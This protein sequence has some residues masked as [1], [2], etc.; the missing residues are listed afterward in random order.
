[1]CLCTSAPDSQPSVRRLRG[2]FI[3]FSGHG[4]THPEEN[5]LVS[6]N[7]E[8]K[9]GFVQR[10]IREALETLK[11]IPPDEIYVIP[12]RLDETQTSY[13]EL[14]ELNWV[15][16]FPSDSEGLEKICKA[17]KLSG[18]IDAAIGGAVKGR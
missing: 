10:E 13:E 9:R 2:R 17:L 5:C 1:M 14:R 8:K 3:G 18:R 12:A 4:R 11:E 6:R 16:L 7:S 15:D